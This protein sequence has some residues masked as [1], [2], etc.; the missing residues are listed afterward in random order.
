MNLKKL[1][2]LSDFWPHGQVSQKYGLFRDK[3]GTSQRANVVVDGKGK[4]IFFKN[5]PILSVPDIQEV[6]G[7][8]KGL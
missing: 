5:F 7:F 2:I 8:L 4:I 6:I 3:Y 1:R